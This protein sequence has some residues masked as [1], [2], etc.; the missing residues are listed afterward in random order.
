M[1]DNRPQTAGIAPKADE[2]GAAPD[3]CTNQPQGDQSDQAYRAL[4]EGL[5]AGTL[6][7]GM[8]LSMPMLVTLLAFPLAAVR[9]AVKRAEAAALVQILPKRGVMV[10]TADPDTTR[11]CMDLR[12]MLDLHGARRLLLGGGSLPLASLRATHEA[13]LRDAR[14]PAADLQRRAITTDLSLHDALATGLDGP[15]LRRIYAENRDRIAVIQT[16]RPFLA[17]RILPAMTEHL[18]II[19]ALEARDLP[20]VE[21]AIRDHLTNTLRWWGIAN[22]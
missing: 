4:V 7:S 1:N 6:R 19:A 16:Q 21:Q 2:T 17:D 10:M 8:F 14:A 20:A 13:L 11:D 18:A 5:R 22:R 9:E 15:V 3:L 12:A